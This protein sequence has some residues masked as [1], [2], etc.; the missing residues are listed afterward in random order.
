[1]KNTESRILTFLSRINSDR[2]SVFLEYTMLFAVFAVVV[3]LP[4]MP[5]GPAY[6]FL[7]RELMLRI[8]LISVPFF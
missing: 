5:G 2:A 4:I 6:S 1:M 7:H 3:C 8:V